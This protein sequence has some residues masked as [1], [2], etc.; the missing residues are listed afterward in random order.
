MIDIFVYTKTTKERVKWFDFLL[1]N[2]TNNSGVQAT[3]FYRPYR[4]EVGDYKILFNSGPLG[5]KGY[6]PTYHY[7]TDYESDCCLNSYGS[8]AFIDL[9]C[10]VEVIKGTREIEDAVI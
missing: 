6:R 9:A 7:T 5:F 1:E 10:I 4:I 2:F 8:R 3:S